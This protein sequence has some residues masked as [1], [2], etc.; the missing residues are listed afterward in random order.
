MV[1]PVINMPNTEKHSGVSGL[2]TQLLVNHSGECPL[3]GGYAQ[4]LTQWANVPLSQGGP[5]ASWH[6]FSDPIAIVSMVDPNFAAWHASEANPLSEGFEQAGY[7]R[8]SREEWLTAEGR[9]SID[10]HAWIL[11]QRMQANGIPHKWLSTWEVEQVTK[12]GNR[13]IKGLCNHRQIDPETRTDPGDN[14]P[15]D[16]LDERIRVHLGTSL[17]PQSS[18]TTPEGATF[19]PDLNEGEQ[20]R[21]LAAADRINGVITDPEAKVLTTKHV[22]D[23][24]A[25]TVSAVL[26]TPVKRAGQ[27]AGIGNGMTSLGALVSWA[28]DHTVQV[29]SAVAADAADSGATPEEIGAE[30]RKALAEGT[31]KV[32][33]SLPKAEVS[34]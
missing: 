8:F 11:A 31:L 21:I 7:A 22:A 25:Q 23:I 33:I 14:Y 6:W 4:S 27:G 17:S 34:E 32:D 10:N 13:S 15:F 30:V 24:V 16:Y 28:D 3:R 9:K 20:R 26:N 5:E 1:S 18:V 19:M 12:Y 2:P 29:L